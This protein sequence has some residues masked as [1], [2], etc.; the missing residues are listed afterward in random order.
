MADPGSAGILP[1]AKNLIL[2]VGN[3]FR[4]DDGIG[5]AVIQRCQAED[6]FEGVDLLDGG[7]DGFSLLEYI[8]AY[9]NV[10]VVDA[11]EMGMTP[12]EIRLFSPAEAKLTL[13]SE[14]LSTHGF[15]LAEVI[16]LMET[17]G[18]QNN[19][20]IIGI[21]AKD[22]SF[23]EAISPEVAGKM[24][25]ILEMIKEYIIATKTRRKKKIRS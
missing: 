8:K 25:E 16:G 2:G 5:P 13:Q 14:A 3:P 20:R 11:V 10:L 18:I 12:G 21:Q 15:G 1:A 24:D 9:E 19:L 17:L 22:I 7:T 4:R 23:G 6:D